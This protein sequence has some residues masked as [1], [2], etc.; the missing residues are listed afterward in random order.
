MSR[1]QLKAALDLVRRMPPTKQTKT[2][3]AILSLVPND[4]FAEELLADVD[5]P[6]KLRT[7]PTT[8]KPFI[9][10]EFNRDADSFRSPWSNEY[11]PPLENGV[12]PPP[13]L[14]SLEEEMNTIF[15][16]YCSQY[17]GDEGT[18]SVYLWECGGE[19]TWAA[20]V[21]FRKDVKG[22][23]TWNT[24]HVLT[25]QDYPDEKMSCY[26]MT[27]SVMLNVTEKGEAKGNAFKLSGNIAKQWKQYDAKVTSPSSHVKNIGNY[28][29]EYE[30]KLRK[31]LPEIYF[32]KAMQVTGEVRSLRP[33]PQLH[34]ITMKA[35][36]KQKR[37]WRQYTDEE[38]NLYWYNTVTGEAQWDMPDDVDAVKQKNEKKEKKEKKE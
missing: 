14:R 9:I 28:V 21:L 38:G 10:C 35:K 25:I 5:Q 7:C 4:D 19:G 30:N 2:L 12:V 8:N 3:S 20:A 13:P 33:D 15:S 11:V 6:L 17:Y 23:G 37:V 32:G 1:K 36:V 31:N 29:Q 27:S 16:T 18:H 24:I 22:V 26:Q 34:M